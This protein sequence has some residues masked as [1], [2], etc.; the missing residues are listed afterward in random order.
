MILAPDVNISAK[1]FQPLSKY[2]VIKM[3]RMWHLDTFVILVIIGGALGTIQKMMV[4]IK[5]NPGNQFYLNKEKYCVNEC[6]SHIRQ[7]LPITS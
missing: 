5:I 4:H 1:E 6:S 2:N 3:K 7:T